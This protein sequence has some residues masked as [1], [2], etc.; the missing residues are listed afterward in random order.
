MASIFGHPRWHEPHSCAGPDSNRGDRLPMEVSAP[1]RQVASRPQV[2]DTPAH[3]HLALGAGTMAG[4]RARER[5]VLAGSSS[6]IIGTLD[7]KQSAMHHACA[8]AGSVRGRSNPGL[9][10]EQGACAAPGRLEGGGLPGEHRRWRTHASACR[11]QPFQQERWV[12]GGG[13]RPPAPG[14]SHKPHPQYSRGAGSQAGV[15]HTLHTPAGGAAPLDPHPV[16]LKP[17][18]HGMC[19]WHLSPCQAWGT[20]GMHSSA[21]QQRPG[22]GRWVARS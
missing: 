12:A 1:R 21:C 16:T 9:N 2:R 22:R 4:T 14:Y 3:P 17:G 10:I 20:G 7:G 5:P 6:P 8:A 15:L 11:Q 18:L 13:T 19:T